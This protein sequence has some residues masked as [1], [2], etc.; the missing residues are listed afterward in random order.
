MR[1]LYVTRR[2][3]RSRRIVNEEQIVKLLRR[4]GFEIVCPGELSF[5]EQI[6]L[7]AQARV[8]IGPHG[9]GLTNTVFAPQNATLIELFPENYININGCYWALANIC[10]QTYAFLTGT[11]EG[12]DFHIDV[13]KLERLLE[14]ALK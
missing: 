6:R 3:A 7:F 14:K 12:T 10:S 4:L 5:S 9:A 8:I 1:L 2:D 13:D 11:S